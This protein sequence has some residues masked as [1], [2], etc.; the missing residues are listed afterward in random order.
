MLLAPHVSGV[1][2]RSWSE[3]CTQT[4][5]AR[6]LNERHQVMSTEAIVVIVVLVLVFGG[7][8]YYWKRR[9]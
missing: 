4:R 6:R 1:S 9:G 2:R 8:G 3:S 7:G 5:E